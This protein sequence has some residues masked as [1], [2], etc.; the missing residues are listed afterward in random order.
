MQTILGSNGQIGTVL[1]KDLYQHYTKEIRLVG[2]HP[3]KI[4]DT[5]EL[6]VA[7]LTDPAQTFEA[8]A[9][10]EVVY[11][12]VGLPMDATTWEEQFPLIVENVIQAT[13]KA[14][15]MLAFFDNTYM[16]RKDATPQMEASPFVP[17][18]RKSVVRSKIATRL[19]AAMDNEGLQA[20]IGRAPEF[21]GPDRT[22]GITNGMLFD[23]IKAGQTPQVPVNDTVLRTFIWTPDA[24]RALALLGNTPDAYGQTWHLPTEPG[25]SYKDLIALTEQVVGHKVTYDII[26]LDAFREE[27]R[28]NHIRAE[29]LEI[30]VRY[31]YDNIFVTDKFTKRFPTFKVTSFADGVRTILA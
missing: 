30:L 3:Q 18:G 11:F 29:Q 28:E 13:I 31:Q 22:Q 2:R 9:G 5:D 7:D 6:M 14:D 27:A 19:L 23:R 20:V 12:T 25:I 26:S 24:S 1:A 10:S 4:H 21:Y 15:A 8:I 16:Y 17:V